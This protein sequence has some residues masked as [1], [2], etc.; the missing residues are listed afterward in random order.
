MPVFSMTLGGRVR[1]M[2]RTKRHG[3]FVEIETARAV[4]HALAAD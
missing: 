1:R 4:G 3:Y 2:L